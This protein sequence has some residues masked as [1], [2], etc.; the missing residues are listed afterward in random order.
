[1]AKSARLKFSEA[2]IEALVETILN[3]PGTDDFVKARV[4]SEVLGKI[5]QAKAMFKEL[6][7]D[8]G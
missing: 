3:S 6:G 7:P 1:M 4:R 5:L 2:E 8:Q